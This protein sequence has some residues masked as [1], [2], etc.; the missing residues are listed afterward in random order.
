MRKLFPLLML[1][2]FGCG[3]G[4][5]SAVRVH[6]ATEMKCEESQLKATPVKPGSNSFTVEGCDQIGRY[7]GV[8]N[9][10]G[11]CP[12]VQ[13]Q[14]ITPIL[15]KQAA[16]DLNC[17]EAELTIV[18]LNTDTFGLRGCGRQASYILVDCERGN[19]RAVQNTQTQ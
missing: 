15:R 3:S 7:F 8:C 4:A 18:S 19:C 2:L 9:G 16:F 14:L 13:G 5:A 10:F 11:Y 1:V 17:G 12:Q 6:A